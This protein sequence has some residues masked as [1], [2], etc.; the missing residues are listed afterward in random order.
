MNCPIWKAVSCLIKGELGKI[1]SVSANSILDNLRSVVN[2][3]VWIQTVSSNERAF[4]GKPF[5]PF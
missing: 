3:D 2:F 5:R 4:A 1:L